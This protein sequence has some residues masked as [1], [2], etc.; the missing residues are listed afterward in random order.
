MDLC[1]RL[2]DGGGDVSRSSS[3]NASGEGMADE[4]GESEAYY[5]PGL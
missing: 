2:V 3:F 1:G 4:A 5:P